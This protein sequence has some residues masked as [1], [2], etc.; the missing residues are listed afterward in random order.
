MPVMDGLEMVKKIK[1]ISPDSY[2]IFITAFSDTQYLKAAIELGVEGYL[3]KPIDKN[4]LLKKLNF[5]AEFIKN[6]KEKKE[7]ER[8]LVEQAKLASLGEMIGNIAHQ[9]RQP[10]SVISTAATGVLM[11]KEYGFLNDKKL[12]EA[13]EKINEEVQYL[14]QTIDDFR[15]FLIKNKKDKEKFKILDAINKALSII[16]PSLK[17]HH[18]IL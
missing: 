17:N 11:Q 4:M 8:L 7:K 3:T 16:G 10:L 12:V 9:W 13:C 5:L 14:S 6:E 2:V 1:E 15:N 18:T